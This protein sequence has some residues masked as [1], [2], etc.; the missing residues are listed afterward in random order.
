MCAYI[1][2]C[3]S[4]QADTDAPQLYLDNEGTLQGLW[5]T[6]SMLR[7]AASVAMVRLFGQSLYNAKL[8]VVSMRRTS[9]HPGTGTHDLS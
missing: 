1:H 8:N 9:S 4:G 2:F 6:M 7:E 3:A 5:T